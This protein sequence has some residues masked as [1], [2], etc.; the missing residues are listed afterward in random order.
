MGGPD[1]GNVDICSTIH[2]TAVDKDEQKE[3]GDGGVDPRSVGAS[4][5]ILLEDSLEDEHDAT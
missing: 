3:K 5:V 2:S 4:K 1:L